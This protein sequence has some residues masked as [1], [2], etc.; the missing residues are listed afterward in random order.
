MATAKKTEPK[1]DARDTLDSA[2]SNESSELNAIAVKSLTNLEEKIESIDW[3]LWE[4]YNI[5]K[6]YVE[7]NPTGPAPAVSQPQASASD[8]ASEIAKALG[9]GATE[10][11]KSTVSKLCGG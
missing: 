4:I 10:K 9:G 5:V 11:N 6:T 8:I 7:N 1:K 3:K 2:S